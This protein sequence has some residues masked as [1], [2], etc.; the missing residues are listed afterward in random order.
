MH[1]DVSPPNTVRRPDGRLVVV[2]WDFTRL[3][4]P[5][6]DLAWAA[7][8]WAPLFTGRWWHAEYDIGPDDGADGDATVR[9]RTNLAA[10]IEGYDCT[11]GQ[12]ARLAGTIAGVMTTHADDLDEMARTDPAFQALVDRGYSR[13]ARADAQWWVDVGEEWVTEAT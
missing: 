5:L 13:R 3:G 2:D 10:V 12:R 8:R 4:D 6:E 7:W 9:Q 1:H 11:P